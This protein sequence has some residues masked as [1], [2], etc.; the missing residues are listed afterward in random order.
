MI[1]HEFGF[2]AH[3]ELILEIAKRRNLFVVEDAACS[4]GTQVNN[5]RLGVFGDLA[6]FSFHPRKLITSG[7]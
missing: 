7:E 3:L 2:P 4:L 1:V 6:C 5:R